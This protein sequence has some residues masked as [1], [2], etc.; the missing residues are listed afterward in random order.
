MLMFYDQEFSMT[1]ITNIVTFSPLSKLSKGVISPALLGSDIDNLISSQIKPFNISIKNL[2]LN[3]I[4][5][6]SP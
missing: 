3:P 5:I 2:E 1:G 6:S 4:F